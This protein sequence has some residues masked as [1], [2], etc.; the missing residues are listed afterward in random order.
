[1]R[2]KLELT[3][4]E[5]RQEEQ[6][7]SAIGLCLQAE[8]FLKAAEFTWK[9]KE[10]RELEIRFDDPVIFLLSHGIELT[11][12]AW[13]RAS[14]ATLGDLKKHGHDLARLYKACKRTY[15]PIDEGNLLD[16]WVSEI[17]ELH[18]SEANELISESER[19]SRISA[20]RRNREVWRNVLL[21][22]KLH[23]APYTSRYHRSGIYRYPNVEFLLMCA[24]CLNSAIHPKCDA[25]Y[26]N[27]KVTR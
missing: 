23:D 2:K 26:N 13:L 17:Q 4:D 16:R 18:F 6:R 27:N 15:L 8:S 10:S 19:V 11:L 24:L 1:L 20:N 12:K 22:G 9:A 14:G 5:L 25:H 21:L 7:T 3:P